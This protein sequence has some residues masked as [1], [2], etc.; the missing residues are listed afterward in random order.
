MKL[1]ETHLTVGNGD[2]LS[3]AVTEIVAGRNARV[4]HARIG[5]DGGRAFRFSNIFADQE[6]DS[7]VT[8]HAYSLGGALARNDV[9]LRLNGEGAEGHLNG[10]SLA[11]GE[12]HIDNHTTIEHARPHCSSREVYKGIWADATC[13][14]P[15]GEGI[16]MIGDPLIDKAMA[17]VQQGKKIDM[18]AFE[19]ALRNGSFEVL[20]PGEN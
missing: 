9:H 20:K 18:Q 5:M 17:E 10:L 16:T 7:A 11:R 6:R 13:N 15:E 1:V 4:E 12:Q 14:T 8:T 3:S 2:S 19:N